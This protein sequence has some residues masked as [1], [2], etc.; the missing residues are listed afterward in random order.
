MNST[1]I[2]FIWNCTEQGRHGGLERLATSSIVTLV[3]V[4]VFY[5]LVSSINI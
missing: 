5:A 3:I 1:A 2:D 4:Q